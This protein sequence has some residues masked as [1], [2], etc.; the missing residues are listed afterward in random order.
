MKIIA[1]HNSGKV[2]DDSE[3]GDII[4]WSPVEKFIK[5]EY[6]KYLHKN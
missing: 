2:F 4:L 5:Q 6:N 1:P 3:K